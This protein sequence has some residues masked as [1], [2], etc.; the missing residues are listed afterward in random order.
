M[1]STVIYIKGKVHYKSIWIHFDITVPLLMA[2]SLIFTLTSI[3]IEMTLLAVFTKLHLTI[4]YNTV[5]FERYN[6]SM[7]ANFRKKKLPVCLTKLPK[8]Y[9]NNK[10]TIVWQYC[11]TS[12]KLLNPTYLLSFMKSFFYFVR[13][14]ADHSITS[15]LS[16][17]Q[18]SFSSRITLKFY[19]LILFMTALTSFLNSRCCY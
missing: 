16:E 9:Q 15:W 11:Y 6:I 12:A 7:I 18:P 17:R 19:I 4:N 2:M 1:L 8:Q 14:I 10:C 3:D 13:H 5:S